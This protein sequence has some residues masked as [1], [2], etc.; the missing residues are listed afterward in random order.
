M[1][2]D[3]RTWITL[4]KTPWGY[5]TKTGFTNDINSTDVIVLS[6]RT[7]GKWSTMRSRIECFLQKA[8]LDTLSANALCEHALECETI[9][10]LCKQGS[11]CNVC[12]HKSNCQYWNGQR[13]QLELST[14]YSLDQ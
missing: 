4:L 8:N 14:L 1:S 6:S 5:L 2:H 12:E 9:V 7:F 11:Y 10:Y 3:H 13:D